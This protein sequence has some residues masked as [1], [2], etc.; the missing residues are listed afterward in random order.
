MRFGGFL[1]EDAPDPRRAQAEQVKLMPVPVMGFV[2]QPTLEDANMESITSQQGTSGLSQMSVSINYTLW[3]NPDDRSDPVN[4]AELD[5][6]TRRALD[7]PAPR[8]RPAWLI[9][10]AERRRYPMLWEAVRT[11]WTRDA[12]EFS[13]PSRLLMDHVN[14]IL[15]NW[16]REQLGLGNMGVDRFVSP[17][18]EKGIN[19]EA[20]VTVDGVEVPALEI[21]TDPL[22]YAIGVELSSDTVLTAVV[23]RDEL[24]YICLEFAQRPSAAD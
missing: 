19:R 14:H 16:F 6:P 8:P 20:I 2:A 9:E 4:L 15:M 13:T 12:S 24:G 1:P 7:E 3:R 22:V 17:L 11:T 10:M 23:P 21:D 18:T 5:E